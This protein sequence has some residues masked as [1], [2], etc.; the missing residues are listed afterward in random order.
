MGH[1][2]LVPPLSI[3]NLSLTCIRQGVF[4]RFAVLTWSQGDVIAWYGHGGFESSS[5]THGHLLHLFIG[6]V[7]GFGESPA[8]N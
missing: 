4:F 8:L 3:F 2:P 7:R 1:H 5:L 6:A